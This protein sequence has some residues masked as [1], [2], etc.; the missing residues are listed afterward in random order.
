MNVSS[1]YEE[2]ALS[3]IARTKSALSEGRIF[4]ARQGVHDVGNTGKL[5]YSECLARMID[6]WGVVHSAGA[7]V[8]YLEGAGGA[9]VLDHYMLEMIFKELE[10]EPDAVLGCNLSAHTLSNP[11]H[12]ALLL[13]SIQR[14]RIAASRLILEV[15]ETAPLHYPAAAQEFLKAARAAGCRIAIDDFGAGYAAPSRLLDVAVDIV[16][17]DASFTHRILRGHDGRGSLYHIVGLAACAVPIVVVE[18]VETDEHL[19]AALAAGATHLQG[20]LLSRPTHSP[21][22]H[23][24]PA[25]RPLR[26]LVR[27][28]RKKQ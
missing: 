20:Y 17:I 25:Y 3:R 14:H 8:P 12:C 23:S 24:H 9:A 6:E 13:D 27:A 4:A 19:Q 22:H 15:T 26:R 28:G 5:L 7:F 10:S 1:I 21:L 2:P 16:K 18:G 11:D